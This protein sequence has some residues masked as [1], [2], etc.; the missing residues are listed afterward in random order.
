SLFFN[1]FN[2]MASVRACR[3]LDN[4]EDAFYELAMQRPLQPEV[5]L[6]CQKQDEDARMSRLAES[7]GSHVAAS[8]EM[9]L[10]RAMAPLTQSLDTF[11]KGA[12]QEQ[13]EGIRRIVGQFVQQLNTSL[14]GQMTALGD[15]MNIVNQGQMQTQKNLQ[16]TLATARTLAEDARVMQLA[17][18]DMAKQM[19]DWNVEMRR[20]REERASSFATAERANGDMALQLEELTASLARMKQA[21][22]TLTGELDLQQEPQ[23]IYT[24]VAGSEY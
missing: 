11:I 8:L 9:A 17:S 19:S 15:T 23:P 24:P 2:R 12:T 4:F 13:V 6:M 18:S 1:M 20:G 22:D 7:V 5:Q 3:A 14:S 21:V 16:D 10:G